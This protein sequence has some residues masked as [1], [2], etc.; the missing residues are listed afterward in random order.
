MMT[1]NTN[2]TSFA[3]VTGILLLNRPNRNH[4]NVPDVKSEYI[5]KDMPPVFFVRIVLMACGRK[6]AVVSTAAAK[7]TIVVVFIVCLII[8]STI[9]QSI[10]KKP[11]KLIAKLYPSLPLN[12]K[13]CACYI[14]I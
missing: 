12:L 2:I 4:N 11:R 14:F 9:Y 1:A 10:I 13:T 8:E 6:D 5:N 3:I 7:P